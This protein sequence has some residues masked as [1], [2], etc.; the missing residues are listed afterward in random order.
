MATDEKNHRGRSRPDGDVT[1]ELSSGLIGKKHLLVSSKVLSL[2]SPV[3]GKMFEWE[4]RAIQSNHVIAL[5][6]DDPEV[7]ILLCE[8]IPS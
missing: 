7:F 8:I 5:P 2:V 4:S 3:L 6:D 1:F